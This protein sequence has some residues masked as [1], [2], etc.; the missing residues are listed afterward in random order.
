MIANTD[1]PTRTRGK[2]GLTL[3]ELIVVIVILGVLSAIAI[4]T[5]LSINTNSKVTSSETTLQS[6]R[7]DASAICLSSDGPGYTTAQMHTC[8]ATATGEV[9]SASGVGVQASGATWALNWDSTTAIVHV[10]AAA[11]TSDGTNIIGLATLVP[12]TNRAAY[13]S[14]PL[15]GG[16]PVKM[17]SSAPSS[18]TAN[19]AAA[20]AG[21]DATA[22][23]SPTGVAATPASAT[24]VTVSWVAPASDG[25][26]TVTTYTVTSSP[27]NKTCTTSGTS[28]TVSGLSTGTPYT[29]TVTATNAI[30]TS[31]SSASSTPVAPA[32][33][34]SAP[35]SVTAVPVAGLPAG[36]AGQIT[37]SWNV[38]SSSNGS[39][40]THYSVQT[41]PGTGTCNIAAPATSCT[42][43]GLTAG[44]AY[45]F[46]AV[47]T[48]ALGNSP[49]S[50]QSSAVTAVTAAAAPTS[51]TA[52]VSGS[53]VV[54]A[55]T[56]PVAIGGSAII[57]YS[58]SSSPSGG[59]C[60]ALTASATT[61]T[62]TTGLTAGTSYTFSVTATNSFS[63]SASSSAS[64]S[65]SIPTV[66]GAPTGVTA[67][68]TTTST[69]A[70]ISW[71]APAS[72]GG[73]AITGF[74][75]TSAPTLAAPASCFQ[76]LTGASTGCTFTGLTTGSTYT[77][78]VTATNA[79]GTGASSSATASFKAGAPGAPTS[80]TATSGGGTHSTV[81]WTAP[82]P[83]W[84]AT[85][86][87]YT[88]TSS[89]GQSCTATSPTL[90]CS[91]G[92]L[93]SGTPYTFTVK[94]T[95]IYGKGAA[96][97]ASGSITP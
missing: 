83:I 16:G 3:L 42:V 46:T 51:V 76:A 93:T 30:G 87:S 86:S 70:V 22:P 68:A 37:V 75:V 65:V 39:A 35:T 95:N 50:A 61:C 11:A 36:S 18:D 63:T 9:S 34:P 60:T 40:V 41:S 48:N 20:L 49:A 29:F 14:F 77:F 69:S 2:R 31:S 64:A 84:G 4:P 1:S 33:A 88:V 57:G 82:A 19:P 62:V 23:G 96:S 5:F 53:T 52:T 27:D 67:K 28:C 97:A 43:G 8:L 32:G 58:V 47:A 25:G 73:S 17:W 12:G 7:S 38:P 6:I 80:V 15:Y 74:K 24:S 56:D 21:P 26:S 90:T 92:G 91:V 79:A 81:S 94:A 78:T 45:R 13:L 71:T 85:T 89:G 10:V 44:T 59:I 66:P 72:D 54:V 55:W